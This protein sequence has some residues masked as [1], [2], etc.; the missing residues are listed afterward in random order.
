MTNLLVN[1]D[2]ETGTFTPWQTDG[3][4][5]YAVTIQHDEGMFHF[6]KMEVNDA[7]VCQAELYQSATG[8]IPPGTLL[9]GKY[10]VYSE[11]LDPSYSYDI[12]IWLIDDE[13]AENLEELLYVLAPTGGGYVPFS[14]ETSITIPTSGTLHVYLTVG[15]E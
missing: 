2:F 3:L 14:V 9:S 8:P 13:D 5:T 11:A 15:A 12:Q 10:R 4:G 1:G 7:G 6:C